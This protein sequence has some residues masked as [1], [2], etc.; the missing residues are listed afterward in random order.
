MNKYL[1]IVGK[2][3]AMAV[4]SNG[5]EEAL[6]AAKKDHDAGQSYT[7]HAEQY[8]GQFNDHPLI[9]PVCTCDGKAITVKVHHNGWAAQYDGKDVSLA[10]VPATMHTMIKA[11]VKSTA[12]DAG[13]YTMKVP[14]VQTG[15]WSRYDWINYV[16]FDFP[17]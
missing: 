10:D 13:Y 11:M 1:V 8:A 9:V 4:L 12:Y 5:A 17:I 16:T 6:A 2:G 15:L 7:V 3:P 14:P